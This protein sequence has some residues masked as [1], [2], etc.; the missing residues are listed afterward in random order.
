MK[1]IKTLVLLSTLSFM[2]SANAMLVAMGETIDATFTGASSVLGANQ[3]LT[4]ATKEVSAVNG[5]GAHLYD[6]AEIFEVSV[7]TDLN[8]I[9]LGE[10]AGSNSILTDAIIAILDSNFLV[11]A[12]ETVD[13][14]ANA[15]DTTLA[16]LLEA[17][18]SPY[19]VAF[20][21]TLDRSLFGTTS[22][23]ANYI[24]EISAVPVPAAVW[25]FGTA[26]LGL[27]G[28]KR[29]AAVSEALAA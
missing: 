27:I 24:L 17:A 6:F 20:I 3:T 29:K 2:G 12:F 4:L 21:G 11:K 18:N 8:S 15:G 7:A 25:L 26:L 28:F 19:Y 9:S 5:V 14:S 13:L 16:Y 10:S 23:T 22:G 1:F